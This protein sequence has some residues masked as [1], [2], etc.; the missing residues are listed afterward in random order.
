MRLGEKANV[1][2]ITESS[3][4]VKVTTST[5]DPISDGANSGGRDD[6]LNCQFYGKNRINCSSEI[7]SDPVQWRLSREYLDQQIRILRIQLDEMKVIRKHLREMRPFSEHRSGELGFVTTSAPQFTSFSSRR[8]KTST[9]TTTEHSQAASSGDQLEGL[10]NSYVDSSV[11]QDTLLPG[12]RRPPFDKPLKPNRAGRVQ[13][14]HVF[15]NG[16]DDMK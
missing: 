11:N 14:N 16:P 5:A 7:Y 13:V 3:T 2:S 9:T 4:V 1:S 12:K 15:H 8:V 6:R 10:R